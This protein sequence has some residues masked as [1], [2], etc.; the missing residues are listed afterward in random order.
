MFDLSATQIDGENFD[1]TNGGCVTLNGSFRRPSSSDEKVCIICRVSR[2]IAGKSS[3]AASPVAAASARKRSRSEREDD[4]SV[5]EQEK[6]GVLNELIE[7]HDDAN[8]ST[9]ELRAKYYGTGVNGSGKKQAVELKK[10][11]PTQNTFKTPQDD[12]DDDDIGF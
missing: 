1:S 8:L 6:G 10:P 2:S 12:D 7:L 11:P 5:G 9:E 4:D 3:T